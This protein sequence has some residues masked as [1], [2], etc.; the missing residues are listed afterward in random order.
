MKTLPIFLL[1]ACCLILG[2]A[3]SSKACNTS[4]IKCR[5]AITSSEKP[6]YYML[7]SEV[8]L[9][10]A[11]FQ[12]MKKALVKAISKY[13]QKIGFDPN[14]RIGPL[15]EYGVQYKVSL[16]KKG[17]K[18]VWINGFCKGSGAMYT[19]LNLTSTPVMMLDGGSCY[20]NTSINLKKR[21]VQRIGIH[22][23]A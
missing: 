17:Q 14:F 5:D 11:E 4:S 22:G 9:T 20:F 16:T 8:E 3:N 23:F 19:S 10:P 1:T 13:N 15:A 2:R 21:K 6:D 18:E 7:P 12:A